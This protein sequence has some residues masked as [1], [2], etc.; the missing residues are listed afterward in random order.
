[1]MLVASDPSMMPSNVDHPV[2]DHQ[3]HGEA[4]EAP[5][6]VEA[7]TKAHEAAAA[8]ADDLSISTDDEALRSDFSNKNSERT[9]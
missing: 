3:D 5:S 6:S 7:V 9:R 1:M 2:G 8:T 4:A